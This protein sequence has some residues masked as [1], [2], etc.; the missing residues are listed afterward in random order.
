MPDTSSWWHTS[1]VKAMVDY[2]MSLKQQHEG[3]HAFIPKMWHFQLP[4]P[5]AYFDGEIR[6]NMT[7]LLGTACSLACVHTWKLVLLAFCSKCTVQHYLSKHISLEPALCR[8]SCLVT[9]Y[10]MLE[11]QLQ[12]WGW[13]PSMYR[14]LTRSLKIQMT[15]KEVKQN[16]HAWNNWPS[17]DSLQSSHC[18]I[19][20]LWHVGVPAPIL[21]LSHLAVQFPGRQALEAKFRYKAGVG[22]CCCIK[23]VCI[24]VV[25]V[26]ISIEWAW[27]IP[28]PTQSHQSTDCNISQSYMW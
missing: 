26:H 6:G 11:L 21:G 12:S 13:V 3:W 25:V 27:C 23:A 15:W 9:E 10:D 1:V 24:V 22:I 2:F 16:T 8:S 4:A 14:A 5:H 28:P 17:Q 19:P 7:G 18:V 20:E